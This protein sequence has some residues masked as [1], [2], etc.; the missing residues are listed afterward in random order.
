MMAAPKS[1]V[2]DVGRVLIEWDVHALF[3]PLLGGETETQ[4]FLVETDFN[5]WN[6]SLDKGRPLADGVAD[7]TTRF[8]HHEAAFKAF[9]TRWTETTPGAIDG[10]VAILDALHSKGVPLYGNM[11]FSAETWPDA[12]KK[13]PLLSTRFRD[14]VVSGAEGL[15]KPDPNFYRA[16]L[17]RNGLIA[18]DCLFI[19]DSPKN[20][21]GARDVGMQAI[22]FTG[23]HALRLALQR[24]GFSL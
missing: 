13:Y 2:F 16:L 12:C 6:L 24:R 7:M 19:D 3:D 18:S 9:A 4:A 8:P 23:P 1:I 11:N 22:K 10:T 21:E 20:V 14:V 17:D 15:L 5:A